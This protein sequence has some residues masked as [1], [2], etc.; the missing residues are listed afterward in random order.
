MAA[1]VLAILS[2]DGGVGKTTLC[3]AM[4]AR[5]AAAG[6]KALV[7]DG[8]AGFRRLDMALGMES[9]V[10][11]D[12]ADAAS[13]ACDPLRAV[14]HD[15]ARALPDMLAAP[16]DADV[17]PDED[18][19]ARV[20][21]AFR[22]RYDW[23]A[24]DAPTGIGV[25]SMLPARLADRTYVALTPDDGSMRCAERVLDKLRA[26]GHDR[27]QP[28]SLIINKVNMRLIADELQYEPNI[29]AMTLD[30]RVTGVILE[31]EGLRL[32][33]ARARLDEMDGRSSVAMELDALTRRTMGAPVPKEWTL[34]RPRSWPSR[35][36]LGVVSKSALKEVWS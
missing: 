23:I 17:H 12:A 10:L 18:L 24:F 20:I 26:E 25:W 35:L 27:A 11:F 19:W 9:R 16:F 7:I 4:G 33:Y 5:L 21:A 30:T 31:D 36:R 1:Y 6:R 3:A 34:L 13:G 14:V 15:G 2:G 28:P 29:V 8:N 32:A 22:T